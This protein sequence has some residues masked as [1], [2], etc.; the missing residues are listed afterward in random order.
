MISRTG[1]VFCNGLETT[2]YDVR[3]DESLEGV[4]RCQIEE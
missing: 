3:I 2:G 1:L 4:K